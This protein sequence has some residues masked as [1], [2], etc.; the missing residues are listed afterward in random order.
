MVILKIVTGC[1]LVGALT[2]CVIDQTA[3]KPSPNDNPSVVETIHRYKEASNAGVFDPYD[4]YDISGVNP[5]KD[6]YQGFTYYRRW[7]CLDE[8]SSAAE[9]MK[10]V[11]Q[12]C[13]QQGGKFEA[14][15]CFAGSTG[16]PLYAAKIGGT[17]MADPSRP[18]CTSAVGIGVTA[19]EGLGA[20][21]AGWRKYA[22][23]ELGY[24]SP[25]QR[26]QIEAVKADQDR[27]AAA[28]AMARVD[29][30]RARRRVEADY[31]IANRG[32]RICKPA[33]SNFE[34]VGFVED[35]NNGK[36]KIS[37]VDIQSTRLGNGYRPGWF[38]PGTLWENPMAWRICE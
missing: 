24:K 26:A 6:E 21:P 17:E 18:R 16:E 33:V 28:I 4:T 25:E 12:H 27:K 1:I 2:G 19:I 22:I 11:K 34:Y 20:D 8:Q 9:L 14:S 37:V 30:E 31:M 38:K 35:A 3:V 7:W 36:I 29:N 15:W 10:L 32:T 5:G 13:V 23:E